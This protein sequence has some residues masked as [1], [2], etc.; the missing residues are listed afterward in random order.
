VTTLLLQEGRLW[1]YLTS[2]QPHT[3]I[4]ETGSAVAAVR[5]TRFSVRVADGEMLVSVAE[6]EVELV[7]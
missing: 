6:G 3:F 2:D 1:A 7:A 4:V 5:H